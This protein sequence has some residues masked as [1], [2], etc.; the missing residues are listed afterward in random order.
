MRIVSLNPS[1]GPRTAG[2]A[3][4]SERA[5]FSHIRVPQMII[6][7]WPSIIRAVSPESTMAMACVRSGASVSS[8]VETMCFFAKSKALRGVSFSA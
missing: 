4:G 6:F 1:R 3:S 2:S 8:P 5:L 7:C